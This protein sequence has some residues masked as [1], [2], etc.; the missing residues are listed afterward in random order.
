MFQGPLFSLRRGTLV[1]SRKMCVIRLECVSD[2]QCESSCFK[3]SVST[4]WL[5]QCFSKAFLCLNILRERTVFLDRL[6]KSP[7]DRRKTK[8]LRMVYILNF[9]YSSVLI[10]T[11]SPRLWSFGLPL[12]VPSSMLLPLSV[13]CSRDKALFGGTSSVKSSL[14]RRQN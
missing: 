14:T 7:S 3:T 8:L 4:Q 10:F 12:T 2:P 13:S 5:Q 9:T 6:G 1:D 11:T